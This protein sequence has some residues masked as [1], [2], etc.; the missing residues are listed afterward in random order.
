MGGDGDEVWFYQPIAGTVQAAGGGKGEKP[1]EEVF[2]H[3]GLSLVAAKEEFS[4]SPSN[5]PAS[6]GGTDGGSPAVPPKGRSGGRR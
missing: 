3:E 2:P 4:K 6:L 1:E 5:S